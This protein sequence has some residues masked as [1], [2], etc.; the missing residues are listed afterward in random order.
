MTSDEYNKAAAAVGNGLS[1]AYLSRP[2]NTS[3][4]C[5]KHTQ[6]AWAEYESSVKEAETSVP[7]ESTVPGGPTTPSVTTPPE[8]TAPPVT[9]APAA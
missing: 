1:A 4:V 3:S 6:E 5:T 2:G 8:T 7:D 9:E